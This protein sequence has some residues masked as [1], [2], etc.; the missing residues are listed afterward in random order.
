MILGKV[1]GTIVAHPKKDVLSGLKL[2]AVV[3]IDLSTGDLRVWG[4]G[5][6]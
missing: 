6:S 1:V 3:P 5:R 2:L 4:C